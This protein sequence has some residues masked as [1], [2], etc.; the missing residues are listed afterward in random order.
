MQNRNPESFWGPYKHFKGQKYYA[1]ARA[2]DPNG[3]EYILYQQQYSPYRF[4]IR[5]KDM[6]EERVP[7][8][9]GEGEIQRFARDGKNRITE[10]EGIELIIKLMKKAPLIVQHS[11]TEEYFTV[12]SISSERN[13]V[14]ICQMN[15]YW[16][17]GYLSDYQ[18]ARRMDL[19]LAFID[20]SY[21]VHKLPDF[22]KIDNSRKF[23]IEHTSIS[24]ESIISQLGAASIDLHIAESGFLRTRRA[25]VDLVDL[26]HIT[27]ARNLW[28]SVRLKKQ[29]EP[30]LACF[31]LK[32]GE[33]VVTH[34]LEKI[35]IPLD[36]AG[37]IEIR[38]TYARLSLSVTTGDY[39]NPGYHGFYPLVI[40][41]D[42]RH[43]IRIHAKEPMLQIM[44]IRLDGVVIKDYP[45]RASFINN[46]G[47][48]EGNPYD[49]YRADVVKR[50][51]KSIGYDKILEIY[52]F[53]MK[54]INASNTEN[55]AQ[56]KER[57]EDIFFSYCSSR[58]NRKRYRTT[59]TEGEPR[60][61][62]TYKLWKDFTQRERNIRTVFSIKTKLISGIFP[63]AAWVIP[64]L[65]DN[66]VNLETLLPWGIP[67]TAIYIIGVVLLF[68]LD[69]KYYCSCERIDYSTFRDQVS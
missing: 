59:A 55:A 46:K 22:F 29:G 18:L 64:L 50:M 17:G 62:D 42:G 14:I 28:S 16:S 13:Y 65:V 54:A 35:R 2:L 47:I 37:K 56:T 66:G 34:T 44:L 31:E 21:I 11:E 33:S 53:T 57:F 6:F 23:T 52:N 7:R 3:C 38:S 5:P 49:F 30:E 26:S 36:C 24:E 61:I 9:D 10:E 20:G 51:R 19:N 8:I 63:V 4:W 41:N 27:N 32:R 15:A 58:V 39:C 25:V 1:Y 12:C 48:D 68:A 43:T 60:R 40:R 45:R 69:P 67:V